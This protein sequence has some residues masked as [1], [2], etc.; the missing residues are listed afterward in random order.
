MVEYNTECL[1]CKTK[2][3]K[4]I[5]LFDYCPICKGK[6]LRVIKKP[7]KY[8]SRFKVTGF[9][10]NSNKKFNTLHFESENQ[11]LSINLWRGKVYKLN[12]NNKY[13]II[14]EVF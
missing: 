4:E 2:Y 8:L 6:N 12:S 11:A 5:F 3:T 9:Y 13:Q 10:Y 7:M 14:K 1:S